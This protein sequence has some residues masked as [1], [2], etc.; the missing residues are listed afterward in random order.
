MM[1]I[2]RRLLKWVQP[3][4]VAVAALFIAFLIV[5][6]WQALRQHAW[7]LHGGWLALATTLLLAAWSLE[8]AIWRHLLAL[9][10]GHLPLDVAGRIW[11]L[12][13]VVR[14]IPGNIWHP[15]SMTVYGQRWGIRPEATVTSIA[16]YQAI[17]LLAVAPIAALY[18]A[19][20]GN[21][22]LLTSSLGSLTPGLVPLLL[23]PVALF[24]LRPQWLLHLTNWGLRRLGRTTLET[25]LS[26]R[27]LCWLLT[28][29]AGDWLLWGGCFAALTFGLGDYSAARLAELL[30]HLVAAYP[31]AYAVGF[32][33]LLTPSGF[34]VR[35]GAFLVLLAP[36]LDGAV[37]TVIALAMR[38][39]TA[40]GEAV[41]ALLSLLM[42][43]HQ[44]AHALGL[45]PRK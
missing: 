31:I 36:L 19:L 45:A 6:Q 22:G 14:Y 23:A 25:R 8:I 20:T 17:I 15:L 2:A 7:Q 27:R 1:A 38:L 18:F 44:A 32:L 30:P 35:E 28:L 10:G 39:F 42:E 21:W 43:R 34:G 40:V 5:G 26:S 3:L 41:M 11:F 13:A 16:L 29:A 12:S 33:S 9:L 37:V 24:L 4:M